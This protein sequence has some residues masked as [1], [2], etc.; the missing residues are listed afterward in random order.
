MARCA[1][2]PSLSSRARARASC[3]S[4]SCSWVPCSRAIEIACS[5]VSRARLA[6][7]RPSWALESLPGHR[8]RF[9][10]LAQEITRIGQ[11]DLEHERQLGIACLLCDA[12]RFDAV[13]GIEPRLA[14]ESVGNAVPV[15]EKSEQAGGLATSCE[16]LSLLE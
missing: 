2:A 10:Q 13:S 1:L 9:P 3:A 7:P 6:P 4:H 16:G 14:R 11:G 5:A 15:F 8:K 12:Q